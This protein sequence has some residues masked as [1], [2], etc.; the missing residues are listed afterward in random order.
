MI[1]GFVFNYS[2]ASRM[3]DTIDAGSLAPWAGTKTEITLLG[4]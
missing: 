2:V 1:P 4:E 3:Q